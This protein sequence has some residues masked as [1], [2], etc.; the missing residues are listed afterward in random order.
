MKEDTLCGSGKTILLV[1]DERQ[2]RNLLKTCFKSAGFWVVEAE[3]GLKALALVERKSIGVVDVL[4]T[5]I[6][7]ANMDGITLAERCKQHIPN[8]R[9]VAI[10]A[11]TDRVIPFV[12]TTVDVF[13]QKPFSP[14]ALITTVA[15]LLLES[16]SPGQTDVG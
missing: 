4:V 14:K 6:E 7:M 10:S 15:N 1:D 9:V 2:V 13:V 16:S 5:D 8:L 11:S 3:S 12:G